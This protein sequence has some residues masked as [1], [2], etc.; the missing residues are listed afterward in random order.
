MGQLRHEL[1]DALVIQR[2]GLHLRN[3]LP[4]DLPGIPCE[5]VPPLGLPLVDGDEILLKD[6]LRQ[7]GLDIRNA[8]PGEKTGLAVRTVAHHVYVRMVSFIV[9]RGVPAELLIGIQISILLVSRQ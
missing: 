1:L 2:P 9:E 5:L 6:L 7:R 4:H 3:E 8:L